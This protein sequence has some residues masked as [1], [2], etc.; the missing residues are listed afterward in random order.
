MKLCLWRLHRNASQHYR[1][2]DECI[3]SIYLMFFCC[4]AS[5]FF[6]NSWVVIYRHRSAG[7]E[8][9]LL[10]KGVRCW[11]RLNHLLPSLDLS[12][13]TT[14]SILDVTSVMDPTVQTAR[15][16]SEWY[17]AYWLCPTIVY[18]IV[19]FIFFLHFSSSRD[20][21]LDSR[22]GFLRESMTGRRPSMLR[23]M[24]KL[25][26]LYFWW[27]STKLFDNQIKSGQNN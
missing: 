10:H 26:L 8:K 20:V 22:C 9:I 2:R 23:F 15:L 13:E 19:E 25:D 6:S 4:H 24:N 1:Y 11:V 16:M 5:H 17:V 14:V 12:V 21:D 3:D 7:K 27:S 18:N